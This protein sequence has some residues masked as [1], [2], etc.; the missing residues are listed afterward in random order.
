MENKQKQTTVP[1]YYEAFQC[2]GGACEDTCCAGW[3][4]PIDAQTLKK[5]KKVKEPIMKRRLDKEI[6][7]KKGAVDASCAAKIK[8]KNNRCAFLSKEGWCDIQSQLGAVYLSES[9]H[10][11]PRTANQLNEQVEYSL[12]L[13]CPEAAR[14]VLCQKEGISFKK[15]GVLPQ[16]AI[17]TISAELRYQAQKP[18]T[19]QDYCEVYR[20]GLIHQLQ[21]REVGISE[22]LAQIEDK[23]ITIN[24]H[25]A[26]HD[27]KKIPVAMNQVT[28]KRTLPLLEREVFE[29]IQEVFKELLTTKKINSASYKDLLP[30]LIAL[31][32]ATYQN[33]LGEYTTKVEETLRYMLEN[34]FVHYVFDRCIPLD[35]QT[36]YESIGRMIDYYQLLRLHLIA[37]MAEGRIGEE[38]VV[39]L[40]QGFTKVYDH[41]ENHL[42]KILRC[43]HKK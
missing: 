23:F 6:V 17:Q 29:H 3:Y 20:D 8:L 27:L 13:S 32:Y 19:W 10:F 33:T 43:L 39:A 21:T 31:E 35:A 2:I 1:N 40:I 37:I 9:C 12:T 34:Y 5:Y 41:G 14:Q 36:P 16:S 7:V 42:S 25:I 18:K 28:K 26:R 4:L 30:S 22:C 38:E 24:Q 11:Y 15:G